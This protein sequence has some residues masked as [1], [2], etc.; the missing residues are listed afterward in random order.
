MARRK[1][2]VGLELNVVDV[3]YMELRVRALLENIRIYSLWDWGEGPVDKMGND[4]DSTGTMA[5]TW[6]V[7]CMMPVICVATFPWGP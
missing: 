7:V 2:T 3:F 6:W 4:S 1:D 5:A